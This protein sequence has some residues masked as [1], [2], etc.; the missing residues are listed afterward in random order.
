MT[1]VSD[2][3]A[4]TFK[5]SGAT[6]PV[7]IDISKTFDKV[8]H[9]CL[10]HQLKCCGISGQVYGL[11]LSFLSNRQL[12]VVLE[13]KSSQ[14]YPLNAGDSQHSILGP[15]QSFSSYMLMTFLM[16]SIILLS[17]LMILSSLSVI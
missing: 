2:R 12:K 8:W 10:L 1:V 16:L 4:G 13:G 6:L 9:V 11:I 3:I 17:M 7:A 14:D 5:R 15:T